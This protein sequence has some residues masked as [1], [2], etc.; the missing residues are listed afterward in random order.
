VA[1]LLATGVA[2]PFDSVLTQYSV[3]AG[4]LSKCIR[5]MH[6]ERGPRVFFQ[7]WSLF[8]AR[9]APLFVIQL[10]LYEQT[11]KWMGMDFM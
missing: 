1:A 8:F 10:P 4:S 2:A 6:K 9:V 7:G 5:E 3:R 11:R